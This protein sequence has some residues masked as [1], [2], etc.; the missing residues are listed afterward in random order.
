LISLKNTQISNIEA[1]TLAELEKIWNIEF[2]LL[3][4]RPPCWEWTQ[5]VILEEN[6][7]VGILIELFDFNRTK[8][9]TIPPSIENFTSLKYL[10][11]RYTDVKNLPISFWNLTTLKWLQ[12]IRCRFENIPSMLG[13]LISLEKLSFQRNALRTIPDT[14]DKLENLKTLDLS[15]NNLKNFPDS[16]CKLKNLENLDMGHNYIESIPESIL[17][18][19]SLKFFNIR[20]KEDIL[21]TETKN[22]LEKLRRNECHV[23]TVF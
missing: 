3:N 21:T 16:I 22:I 15:Y 14:I 17:T 5:N 18:M 6:K 23:P 10:A 1:D 8:L 2:S 19:D 13:N 12:L 7:V 4:H 11:M 9:S 20:G